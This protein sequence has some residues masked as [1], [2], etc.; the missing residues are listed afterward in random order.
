MLLNVFLLL[1][2]ILDTQDFQA[3]CYVLLR[4]E[5][6]DSVY[7][8]TQ[9]RKR[10]H[11]GFVDQLCRDAVAF[12]GCRDNLGFCYGVIS[13]NYGHRIFMFFRR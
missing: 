6:A 9:S 4:D 2:H 10:Q 7:C 5:N 13:A 1:D 8:R 3:L 11:D 12:K